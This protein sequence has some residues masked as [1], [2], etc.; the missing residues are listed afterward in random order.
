MGKQA[1]IY[2]ILGA[3]AGFVG[4]VISYESPASPDSMAESQVRVINALSIRANDAAPAGYLPAKDMEPMVL[5]LLSQA[6]SLRGMAELGPMLNGLTSIQIGA[7]L[8]RL[9]RPGV[10]NRGALISRLVAY[11]TRRDPEAATA[12]MQPRLTMLL[13]QSVRLGGSLDRMMHDEDSILIRAWAQNAPA[14]AL[15][16]ARQHP[17]AGLAGVILANVIEGP[18]VRSDAERWEL[19]SVFPGKKQR[20]RAMEQ[21]FLRFRERAQGDYEAAELAALSLPQGSARNRAI[22]QVLANWTDSDPAAAL[23]RFR[24]LGV[25]LPSLVP[26]LACRAGDRDPAR[27]ARWLESLE[28][29]EVT[30]CGGVL[31]G[32]WAKENPLE[33]FAWAEKHGISLTGTPK[34]DAQSQSQEPWWADEGSTPLTAAIEAKP[35]A[36]IA[37][38]RSMKPGPERTRL[39]EIAAL[40]AGK[41]ADFE[42]LV[43]ELPAEDVGRVVAR[44]GVELRDDPTR[45]QKWAETLPAGPARKAA[46]RAMALTRDGMTLSLPHGQDRDALTS[47]IVQRYP[48]NPAKAVEYLQQIDNPEIRRRAFDDLIFSLRPSQDYEPLDNKGINMFREWMDCPEIPEE[49]K[50]LW[51]VYDARR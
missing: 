27:V 2:S 12:W 14:I 37:W 29:V 9:D 11:W 13:R 47:G 5:G 41:N 31:V 25:D 39:I 20:E 38:L 49:W 15:D 21:F 45:L 33:A 17:E 48:H 46:W 3:A 26:I 8:D 35:D 42:T 24:S 23:A 40:S 51:R 19:L 7:L 36:T 6:N 50:R 16:Y 4:G 34:I 44:I 43:A 22:E 28:A 30:R 1:I 10:E 32:K 18:N